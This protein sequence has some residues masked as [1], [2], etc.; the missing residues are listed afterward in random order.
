MSSTR[1]GRVVKS[2]VDSN[3]TDALAKLKAVRAGGKA[4]NAFE[5]EEEKSVYDVVDEEQY[6]KIVATRRAEAGN[7]KQ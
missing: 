6:S 5:T 2:R 7:Y 3:A 4:L 1:S